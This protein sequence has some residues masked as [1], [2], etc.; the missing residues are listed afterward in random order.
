MEHKMGL[1]EKYFNDM[2]YGT[3]R[4]EMRI[5]DEKRKQMNENDTIFF[6]KEP[7][8]KKKICTKIVKLTLYK[9]FEEAIHHIPIEY[10]ASESD[11]IETYLEDLNKYYSKEEQEKYGVVA[12]EI[13]V[14]EKSCG[15]VVFK[16]EDNQDYVLL[17]HHN[18]GHWGL[19]KGHV[20]DNETEV[21]TALRETLEETGVKVRKI[22][23]FRKAITYKPKENAMKDVIFFIGEPDNNELIPQLSEV[24][25][26]VFVEESEAINLI[27]HDDEKKLLMDAIHY[28][29]NEM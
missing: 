16:R 15:M 1:Q 2:K 23:N 27:S 17:V 26:A 4:I 13:E 14:Q 22:G 5:Y 25:E 10:L 6:L 8:R 9:D 7:D 3:K 18:L 24:Q 19:P 29:K 28:Y 20:E 12:I 21:E 11:S